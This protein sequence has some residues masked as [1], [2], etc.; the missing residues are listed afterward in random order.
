MAAFSRRSAWA[1]VSPGC[2]APL[3]ELEGGRSDDTTAKVP[4]GSAG[5]SMRSGAGMTSGL[6]GSVTLVTTSMIDA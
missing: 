3:T 1:A 6:R 5:I 2:R 4:N